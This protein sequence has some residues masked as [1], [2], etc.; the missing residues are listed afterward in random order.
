MAD[1]Q[2]TEYFKNI[3]TETEVSWHR[4]DLI[5][6]ATPEETAQRRAGIKVDISTWKSLG[7]TVDDQWT[8]SDT[9][10]DVKLRNNPRRHRPLGV[11]E[12]AFQASLFHARAGLVTQSL[13]L[14]GWGG[15]H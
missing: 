8:D 7:F 2:P 5:P 15:S 3:A 6:G 12:D 4:F 13:A 14:H 10:V 1:Y 9:S 11:T